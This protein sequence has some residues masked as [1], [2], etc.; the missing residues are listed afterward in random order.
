MSAGQH[1]AAAVL[2]G[3]TIDQI[4]AV[5]DQISANAHVLRDFLIDAKARTQGQGQPAANQACCDLHMARQSVSMIGAMADQLTG[6]RLVGGP[7]SWMT[8]QAMEACHD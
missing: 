2:N 3:F 4:E 1:A 6:N 8:L 5:L 7:S